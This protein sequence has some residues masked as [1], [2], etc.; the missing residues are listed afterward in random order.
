MFA[1]RKFILKYILTFEKTIFMKKLLSIMFVAI[2]AMVAFSACS[3]KSE[4]I[5][6][7]IDKNTGFLLADGQTVKTLSFG[8]KS[9][10]SLYDQVKSNVMK[11]Y[12]NPEFV[13][14]ENEPNQIIVNGFT[15]YLFNYKSYSNEYPMGARYRIL[16]EF[17]RGKIEVSAS[18]TEISYHEA[19]DDYNDTMEN[20]IQFH[21]NYGYH[22][23]LNKNN[24]YAKRL[25][26]ELNEAANTM[27]VII[28]QLVY[29]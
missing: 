9:K 1:V 25:N 8:W 14:T 6:F 26:K 15:D 23:F 4:D 21:K 7:K 19:S 5:D 17:K 20:Y 10:K 29:M 28:S 3:S 11:M 2:V 12:E 16:F 13:M 27:N 18:I 22:E 24:Y